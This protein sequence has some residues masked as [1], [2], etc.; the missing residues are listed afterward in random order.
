M[1]NCKCAIQ[2]IERLPYFHRDIYTGVR[3]WEKDKSHANTQLV[4]PM[5]VI[6]SP[7]KSRKIERCRNLSEVMKVSEVRSFISY[8]GV[9]GEIQSGNR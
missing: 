6:C 2:K 3:L 9:A 7:T 5:V 4:F 8:L 1:A